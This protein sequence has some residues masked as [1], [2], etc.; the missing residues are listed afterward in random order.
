MAE[1]RMH[2][3]GT[4]KR[5]GETVDPIL[6]GKLKIIQ[7][8][9]GYRF[10]V[11]ALL[12]AHFVRLGKKDRLLELGAGSGV[13]SLI[14][15]RRW[16]CEELV[17]VEIQEGLHEM[18][19]RNVALNGLADRV[20]MVHGDVRSIGRFIEAQSFDAV[21]FNPPYRKI[22][23]GRVNPDDGKAVARH[24]I[25]AKL[26]D[27]LRAAAWALK[28][29]GRVFAIYPATRMAELF[30]HMRAFRLEPKRILIVHSRDASEGEFVLV[31]GRKGGREALKVLA[32]LVIYERTGEYSR[33]MKEVFRD[34]AER[35]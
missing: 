4:L 17:G 20:G 3:C 26:E 28:G 29:P 27:F 7:K 2:T 9:K 5:P 34:L 16:R 18:A 8:E 22:R 11:D 13:I 21:V 10:S 35:A 25:A 23:S 30:V 12:L 24:E 14:L 15:A 6:D 33:A 31:E 1:S 19:L 32:P